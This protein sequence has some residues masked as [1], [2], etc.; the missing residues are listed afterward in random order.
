MEE[1]L[2]N[3]E[4]QWKA[5]EERR[6]GPSIEAFTASA[7]ERAARHQ[8]P[9]HR[10]EQAARALPDSLFADDPEVSRLSKEVATMRQR[11]DGLGTSNRRA[12]LAEAVCKFEAQLAQGADEQR[13]AAVDDALAGHFDFPRAVAVGERIARARH[14]L[15]SAKLAQAVFLR[16]APEQGSVFRPAYESA[17]AALTHTLLQKKREHLRA[18]PELLN[19]GGKTPAEGDAAHE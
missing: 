6:K 14:R 3:I 13:A 12:E 18:H 5:D 4:R 11:L 9:E 15:E 10:F 8:T 17:R 2:S 7:R 1:K 16:S 19:R